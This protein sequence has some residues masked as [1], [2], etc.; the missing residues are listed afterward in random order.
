MIG[1]NGCGPSG[2]RLRHV[3]RDAAGGR[4]NRAR[5]SAARLVPLAGL[6][7]RLTVGAGGGMALQA[8]RLVPLRR[9]LRVAMGIVAGHAVELAYAFFVATAPGQRGS[10]KPDRIGRARRELAPVF[11]WLWHSAQSPTMAGPDAREGRPMAR[12]AS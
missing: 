1:E 11:V 5:G 12:S 9:G 10:L 7:A 3:A 6:P 2:F 8:P 4:L